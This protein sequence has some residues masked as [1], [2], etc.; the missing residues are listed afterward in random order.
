MV[1]ASSF[2]AFHP[3]KLALQMNN[4]CPADPSSCSTI[5]PA[6]HTLVPVGGGPVILCTGLTRSA[7]VAS[8]A[9]A[10]EASLP[11]LL[12]SVDSAPVARVVS[13]AIDAPSAV[14]AAARVVASLARF[15]VR[16]AS[17]PCARLTSEFRDGKS[18]TSE[19]QSRGHL[20]CRLLL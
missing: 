6:T 14:S 1:A 20:V 18:T 17:A 13:V 19:L 10:R 2:T 16:V 12:V 11:M 15:V 5:C 9:C 4:C 3:S 7:L 8:A